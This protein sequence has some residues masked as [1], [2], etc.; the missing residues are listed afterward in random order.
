M[1]AERNPETILITALQNGQ[2]RRLLRLK[3]LM[4]I[5]LQK[6]F[7]STMIENVPL[8]ARLQLSVK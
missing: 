6:F 2:S 3:E 5:F 8:I 4:L 1:K 7:L